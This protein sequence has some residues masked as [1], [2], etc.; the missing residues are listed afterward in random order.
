MAIRELCNVKIS[1]KIYEYLN[2]CIKYDNN[3]FIDKYNRSD[4]IYELISL[5]NFENLKSIPIEIL[6]TENSKKIQICLNIKVRNKLKEIKN[7]TGLPYNIIFSY[8]IFN[9]YNIFKKLNS[10]FFYIDDIDN[11]KKIIVVGCAGE[12]KTRL[13]INPLFEKNKDI[14]LLTSHISK[15]LYECNTKENKKV[16]TPK[17]WDNP[18]FSN[19]KLNDIKKYIEKNNIKI[20]LIDE[21]LNILNIKQLKSLL[22]FLEEKNIKIVMTSYHYSAIN[23]ELMPL[24]KELL[25]SRDYKTI[26]LNQKGGCQ[27]IKSK[28]IIVNIKDDFRFKFSIFQYLEWQKN[29]KNSIT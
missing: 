10:S 15:S 23:N 13:V 16:F 21:T 27:E 8:S 11:F 12:G 2:E 22:L 14:V 19:E 5:T 4:Y 24:F 28:K 18:S 17:D 7:L 9:A 1:E 26:S 25:W 3:F 29:N 20:V 6:N